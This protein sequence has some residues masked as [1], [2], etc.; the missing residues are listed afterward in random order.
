MTNGKSSSLLL[1]TILLPTVLLLQDFHSCA[2]NNDRNRPHI[3]RGIL[4]QYTPGPFTDLV[5]DKGDEKILED[6]KPIMKQIPSPTGDKGGR[7]IC[8]Q[9]VVA[10]K[11]AVWNQILDLN[12]YVGKVDKLKECKNYFMKKNADGTTTIKTKFVVG[13]LPG[14][15]V[16]EFFILKTLN[17]LRKL[18]F[19]VL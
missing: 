12:N 8:V 9:D 2:A 17:T 11:S 18:S 5:L 16:C 14:Y 7:V 4:P 3:H 13:V 10:Q 1:L 19:G 6:G 15:K